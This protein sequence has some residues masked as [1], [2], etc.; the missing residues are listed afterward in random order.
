MAPKPDIYTRA[1]ELKV[2]VYNKSDFA[3]AEKFGA[4]VPQNCRLLL[5]PEWDRAAQM[6]PLIVDYVKAHPQ[7]QVSLQTHKFMAIP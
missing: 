7:W 6:M 2:I 3:F 1:N 5:Q 4:V